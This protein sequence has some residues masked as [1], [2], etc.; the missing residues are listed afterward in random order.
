MRLP[1]A[2]LL[3]SSDTM[4][5]CP[6]ANC[7][8][9]ACLA[10]LLLLW[11]SAARLLCLAGK[12]DMPCLAEHVSSFLQQGLQRQLAA[13]QAADAEAGA[14]LTFKWLQVTS[15]CRQE[16]HLSTCIAHVATNN[17]PLPDGLLASLHPQ[18]VQRLVAALQQQLQALGST[19]NYY[20]RAAR[21]S[22]AA[23]QQQH[24]E[25]QQQIATHIYTTTDDYTFRAA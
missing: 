1:C 7:V 8:N 10:H 12:Y 19:S 4:L 13:S 9:T 23:L 20:L 25:L 18:H 22:Y 6:A 3:A 21:A 17:L 15:Q 24:S 14:A 11:D 2:S 5:L 16:Q